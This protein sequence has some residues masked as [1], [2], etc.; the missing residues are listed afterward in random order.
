M[1]RPSKASGLL[2]CVQQ[3]VS[4]LLTATGLCH[5]NKYC[6]P[7]GGFHHDAPASVLEQRHCTNISSCLQENLNET[8]APRELAQRT[9]HSS[10]IF[11]VADTPVGSHRVS[12]ATGITG[13]E[14]GTEIAMR[15]K[16]SCLLLCCNGQGWIK[17]L[18]ALPLL[19]LK[20]AVSVILTGSKEGCFLRLQDRIHGFSVADSQPGAANEVRG[21]QVHQALDCSIVRSFIPRHLV[22][23]DACLV[24]V[25]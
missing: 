18:R 22:T 19:R 11:F 16:K 20:T 9:L 24:A 14:G 3:G 4:T 6:L 21:V 12:E 2:N 13:W 8:R 25:P 1:P 17:A 5:Q 10:N 15:F 7:Y 23:A